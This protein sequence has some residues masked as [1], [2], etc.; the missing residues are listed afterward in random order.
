ML[1]LGLLVLASSKRAP[2]KALTLAQL[3]ALAKRVGFPDPNLAAAVA[4]AE[5]GGRPDI[6]GDVNL[7]RSIGLW[8][9]NLRAHPEYF[10]AAL[11]D[12]LA[13]ARAAFAVSGGGATWLPWTTFREGLHKPYL[14]GVS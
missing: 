3:R 7:G 2:A 9:I 5:S 10:E 6:V 1:L 13:N 8:Q 4:M 12:P 11:I 14:G